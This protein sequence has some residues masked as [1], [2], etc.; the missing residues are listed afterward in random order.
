MKFP[1]NPLM[2]DEPFVKTL[3]DRRSILRKRI[4]YIESLKE[5]LTQLLEQDDAITKMLQ[6]HGVTTEQSRKF[7]VD[8]IYAPRL[9]EYILEAL[10]EFPE[11]VDTHQLHRAIC[12]KG[13]AVE[14][15]RMSKELSVTKRMYR[16]GH[17]P[18]L[19]LWYSPG[20][21]ANYNAPKHKRR[22][23][24]TRKDS[25]L[26]NERIRII[27]SIIGDKQLKI[28]EIV[29]ASKSTHLPMVTNEVHN[30]LYRKPWLFEN[31]RKGARRSEWKLKEN[32]DATI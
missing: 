28:A 25:V 6:L 4:D 30:I 5:E 14:F 12:A 26:V 8:R 21:I 15:D 23:S 1:P 24:S 22:G 20:K 18:K 3:L 7:T 10:K 17:D 31:T 13:H 19:H 16:L 32:T 11:G 9:R 27:Q 29:E 2:H